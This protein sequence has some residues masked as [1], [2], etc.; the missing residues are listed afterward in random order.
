[1]SPPRSQ[2][3]PPPGIPHSQEG[4]PEVGNEEAGGVRLTGQPPGKDT[5]PESPPQLSLGLRKRSLS[6]KH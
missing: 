5:G 1:M 4:I 6:L 3:K 2:R